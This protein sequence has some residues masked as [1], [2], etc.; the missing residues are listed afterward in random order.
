MLAGKG[1]SIYNIDKI[2]YMVV[3]KLNAM[4]QHK[5]CM[6]VRSRTFSSLCVYVT[7]KFPLSVAAQT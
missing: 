5:R 2:M 3:T 7:S 4:A 6:S 1:D